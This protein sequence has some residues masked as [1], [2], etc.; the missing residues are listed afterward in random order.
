[1]EIRYCSFGPPTAIIITLALSLPWREMYR[2]KNQVGE[3]FIADCGFDATLFYSSL[4]LVRV[5]AHA[6]EKI[7]EITVF[8]AIV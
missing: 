5:K 4:E 1:M 2:A 7:H 6:E 8:V 3:V